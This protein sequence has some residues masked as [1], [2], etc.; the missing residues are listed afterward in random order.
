MHCHAYGTLTLTSFVLPCL[1]Q[2]SLV[3]V[4]VPLNTNNPSRSLHLQRSRRCDLDPVLHSWVS[5]NLC[6]KLARDRMS[7]MVAFNYHA[8]ITANIQKYKELY[9]WTFIATT[10][11]PV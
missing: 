5:V 10:R 8:S 4:N 1:P 7:R 6:A 3:V 11:T 2:Y 9:H